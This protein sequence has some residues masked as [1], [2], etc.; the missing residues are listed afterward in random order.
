MKSKIITALA[1]FFITTSTF[2]GGLLTNTNHHAAYLRMLARGAHIGVDGVYYNPA[3]LAF[4]PAN[5]F[6]LSFTGQSVYQ[7]RDI[8]ARYKRYNLS[9]AGPVGED[10]DRFYHGTA[11]APIMPSFHLAWKT[12]Q[13]T[14]SAS[15]D[16]AG[17]GGKA[18]FDEGLPMFTSA[19]DAL[20][21]GQS[22]K[23]HSANP[24]IPV[25]TPDMY[26]INSSLDGRQY[27]FGYQMGLT[28]KINDNFSVYAG[29][30]MN[31]FDGSYDGFV[32]INADKDHLALQPTF[33]KLG[34][35]LDC[36]QK[37][38]GL[39]PVVGIDARFNRWNFAAKYEFTTNMNI[40]N[41]TKKLQAPGNLEDPSHPMAAFRHGVNTPSD[42]PSLLTIAAE[43][44]ISDKLRAA[45]E[46]HFFDDTHARMAGNKQ[47]YL[48]HGT[49]EYLAGIEWDAIPSLT[50]ST[51]FQITDYGLTDQF[52]SDTSF[53]CD[54]YS[55][56]LGGRFHITERFNIDV[57][58]FWSTYQDYTKKM[59]NYNGT[60]LT[61]EN[62]YSRSNKIFGLSLNYKI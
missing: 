34:L 46:F 22:M 35:A 47:D 40:E 9:Q 30:R 19:A 45:G 8:Y 48:N 43:Y 3:G 17:G 7:D 23:M 27:I 37:G 13:W 49:R 51:G 29:A 11:A 42:I 2:A 39:T 14:L 57:A 12:D 33:D 24:Q 26:T 53:S 15:F 16:I 58:Y 52:Q 20:I 28:Y 32:D 21:F 59:D 36:S 54:S 25:I 18:S 1:A 50:L 4:L 44:Q 56:G 38:W 6:Y 60:G 41:K 55:I 62:T 10:V 5:G 31:Y 61:G